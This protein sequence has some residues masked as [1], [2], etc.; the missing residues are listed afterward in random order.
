MSKKPTGLSRQLTKVWV[1][2]DGG[3][4]GHT[5]TRYKAAPAAAAAIPKRTAGR[6][7]PR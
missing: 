4:N 3:G 7:P 5:H 2:G 6:R 1:G